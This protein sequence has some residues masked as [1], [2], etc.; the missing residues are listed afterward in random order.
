[1]V[2]L[3]QYSNYNKLVTI[4]FKKLSRSRYRRFVVTVSI[5][6]PCRTAVTAENIIMSTRI[7]FDRLKLFLVEND[8]V[9]FLC[10]NKFNDTRVMLRCESKTVKKLQLAAF[11]EYYNPMFSG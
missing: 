11:A 10:I 8:A 9:H 6:S 2:Y 1:M 7:A 5:D 3:H 4:Y